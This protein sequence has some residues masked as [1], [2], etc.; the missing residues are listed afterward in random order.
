MNW[1][2]RSFNIHAYVVLIYPTESTYEDLCDDL[3]AARE[4]AECRYAVFGAHYT[5]GDNDRFKIVFIN[6]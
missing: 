5:K 4:K 3:R 2:K 6:W 1:S